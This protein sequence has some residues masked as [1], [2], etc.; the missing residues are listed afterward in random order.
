MCKRNTTNST[1]DV[2]GY[3]YP[4]LHVGKE[5]YVAFWSIDPATNQPRRKRY[6]LDGIKKVTARRAHADELIQSLFIKLRKGWNPWIMEEDLPS[7][8]KFSDC[9]VKY[10]EY[11]ERMDRKKT[12][13][14][15]LSRISILN[16]YVSKMEVPIQYA[17]QFDEGFINGFLDYVYLER[18]TS[19]RTRNN[20]RGW[21]SA[22]AQFMVERKFIKSN[23][24][25]KIKNIREAE[26][27]RK[28]LTVDQLHKLKE[29]CLVHNKPFYLACCMMYYTFI[30]PTE[31][32]N[33]RLRDFSIKDQ[34][35]FVS[36]EF[37][38]NR[39]DAYVGIN[40]QII[41]LML[42]LEIF[43]RPGDYYLFGDNFLPSSHKVGPDQFNK[44]FAKVR[45]A[46][47]WGSQYQFYSLKDSGIRDLAN[48][49]G[50][51]V[52]RDQAR[53]HD[54]ATTNKYIQGTENVHKETKSFDG[55]L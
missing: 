24:V 5:W 55:N 14:S 54:I 40:E 41:R 36:H 51:V 42:D 26:K 39:R 22:F 35:V 8:E 32:S 52:A 13:S 49:E 30:R 9:L 11:V 31:L 28:D 20:Y 10:Q 34:T 4:K 27:I 18:K 12:R 2:L 47:H 46:L 48:A 16:E 7:Y 25:E 45:E 19:A 6:M 15:Y 23:P 21:C 38:K 44:E 1:I 37:S 50:I 33:L 17:Y 29:Y 43:S 3:T 53:H